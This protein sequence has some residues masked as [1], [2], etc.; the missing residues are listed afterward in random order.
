MR[1][2]PLL[3][4]AVA[5]L[6]A[7]RASADQPPG[8]LRKHC[9]D[10]AHVLLVEPT[11][12]VTP[13]RFKVLLVLRGKRYRPGQV[14]AP[15]FRDAAVLPGHTYA[16]SVSALDRDGNESPRSAEVEETLPQQ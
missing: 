10:A 9:I 14:V 8:S 15:S 4:V 1:S 2:C 11:D 5:G 12:P 16:Y 7:G 13:M 6:L 3:A